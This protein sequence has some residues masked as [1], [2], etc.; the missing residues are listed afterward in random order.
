MLLAGHILE[1]KYVTLSRSAFSWAVQY[2]PASRI[3][4]DQII[5]ACAGRDA[6]LRVRWELA[7]QCFAMKY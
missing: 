1:A 4:H 3:V 2:G 6:L 7:G 5:R